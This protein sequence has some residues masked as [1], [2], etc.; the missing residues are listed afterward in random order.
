MTIDHRSAI[1]ALERLLAT[2]TAQELLDKLTPKDRE[3]GPRVPS[4]GV[5]PERIAER[6]AALPRRDGVQSE[7]FDEASARSAPTYARNIENFIGTLKVP[8][9]VAGPLRVNGIYAQGDYYVPLAT[10]EAAL[11]ASY[12]RGA[13]LISEAGGAAAL[14][15]REGVSRA[16]GFAFESLHD[17]GRFVAWVVGAVD[18]M[19]RVAEATSRHGK[20][21][22]MRVNIEGN[23]VYLI[24]DFHTADAAG[25]NMVTIATDA[26]FTYIAEHAPVKPAYGFLE[27]NHSGDKKASLQ[28]FLSG[29]GRSVTCECIVPSRL[30]EK[31][32]HTTP[33]MMANYWAMSAMGGVLSGTIGVQGH[34]AN[35][36]AATYL[37]CGQ[38][39]ACVA[40][41]AVGV[42]R[43]EVTS[44][45]DL[46]ASVTLPNLIV[47]TV[48]GGTSLPSQRA[49][50]ELLGLAGPGHANA[51]AEVCAALSL[52][53][54]LSIV[55]A[56]VAG[57]FA[58][59]H[60]KLARGPRAPTRDEEHGNSRSE[61]A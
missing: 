56:L 42:T 18:E 11:V 23:H 50:L 3:T 36:L 21:R 10:T 59:A 43:F 51:F 22:D 28:S 4:G 27:A 58:G 57:H 1:S 15:L 39:V 55:G 6:W 46:Y 19:R 5:T 34:Y 12:C 44:N 60:E 53:G 13:L 29:R 61:P 25:Q 7:L 24:F 9:G 48:G 40:E 45:G 35:G 2:H 31:R 32:L 41:S 20:L 16:P 33:Q 30:V 14:L 26:I 52:A 8:V 49:C 47:G 38:D 17:V 54:E 37:A